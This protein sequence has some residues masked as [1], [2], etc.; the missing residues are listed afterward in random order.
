[1]NALATKI[2]MGLVFC[3][4]MLY[5]DFA[6]AT[7]LI[8][9]DQASVIFRLGAAIL[10]Y[11]HIGG[12]A[13]GLVA[14][15]TAAL[16]RKG[17]KVHRS[18]GKVFVV[19]MLVCYSIGAA[20]AP[21]LTDGQR[22]NFV[23]AILALYLLVTGV[24]AAKRR[25][26]IAGNFEKLGLVV[27]LAITA[28]GLMFMRMASVSETGTV[29]GSPPEAFVI[30]VFAG[31]LAAIGELRVIVSGNLTNKSRI[32]RHV[33]RI[34]F[35]LFFASAS[36]FFGQPQVFPS[37]FNATILPALLA[38]FPMMVL[39]IYVLKISVSSM[40]KKFPHYIVGRVK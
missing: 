13:L 12:G 33:W 15:T 30:F 21:F 18:A 36:L 19:A 16:S 4:M 3:T 26:F 8:V 35:S 14:G 10:L 25:S 29:D 11:A 31:S 1:M 27:A 2:C 38:V 5:V 22:P 24:M 32:I 20:V 9:S 34:C 7:K 28:M 6:Y 40:F 17:G 39:L 37:W 23:A